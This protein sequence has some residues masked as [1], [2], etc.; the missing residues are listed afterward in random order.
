[1]KLDA[2]ILADA[3]ATPDGDK[4][5]VHGGG[6][7]RIE[8]PELPA[9]IPFQ[10]LARFKIDPSDRMSEHMFE[11]VLIGPQG[12]PNVDP[13]R[14]IAVPPPHEPDLAEGEEE[15]LNIPIQVPAH[16]I[17][18]GLYHL[19][20]HLQDKRIR[21]VPLPVVVVGKPT[22]PF[23]LGTQMVP[24]SRPRSKGRPQKAKS[25]PQS[26]KK[27]SPKPKRI[28]KSKKPKPKS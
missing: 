12:I 5:F 22:E 8:V 6:I 19:E 4:F 13:I 3:V 2:I 25:K 24:S 17:R 11:V 28:S 15:Y 1:M 20:V 21:R 7:T 10:V 18:D 16:A 9:E 26:T 23:E 14:F 27:S